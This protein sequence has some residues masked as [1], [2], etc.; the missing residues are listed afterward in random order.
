MAW[1]M[2]GQPGLWPEGG[3][4]GTL[5]LPC[6]VGLARGRLFQGF[7]SQKSWPRDVGSCG[8]VRGSAPG[9]EE[10]RGGQTQAG[11]RQSPQEPRFTGAEAEMWLSKRGGGPSPQQLSVL[12]S[13]PGPP[14][15]PSRAEGSR[16]PPGTGLHSL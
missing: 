15:S 16:P 5:P 6:P 14:R 9:L 1:G 8:Q 4:L 7:S 13:L 10:L 11:P 3:T 12:R 2:R